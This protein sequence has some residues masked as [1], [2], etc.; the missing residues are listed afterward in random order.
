MTDE[1]NKLN[2]EIN[3]LSFGAG[4]NS[5]ALIIE[6][7]K[8]NMKPDIVLFADTGSEQPETYKHLEVMERWFK[9]NNINFQIV[10][11]HY[12]QKLYDYY[13][14]KKLTPSRKFRD[15]TDKFKKQPQLKF[16]RQFKDVGVVQHIGIAYDEIYRAIKQ[17][18]NNKDPKWLK[19][20]YLL[21]E[22]K[23]TRED[24]IKTIKDAGL[25]I[26][27]KSGCFCCPFQG[28]ESWKWLWKTHTDLFSK[29]IRMEEQGRRFPE[30]TLTFSGC[31]RDYE[32]AFKEQRSLNEFFTQ[33][34]CDGHCWT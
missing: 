5:T 4:V 15:C 33:Q 17:E 28:Q 21:C 3:I 22:W 9:I 7:V 1:N 30:I 18:K 16:M 12:N 24:N 8:R 11:S 10:R 34:I 26:P 19:T 29:A 13:F 14:D 20:R 25:P 32:K 27:I 31:L 2:S 6:M 23:M